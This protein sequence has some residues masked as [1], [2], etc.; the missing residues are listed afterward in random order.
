MARSRWVLAALVALVSWA[1]AA[2]GL[3]AT[4]TAVDCGSGANLQAA[5]TAAKPGTILLVSGACHG[6][7]TVGK[8]LV[9]KGASG[10][11]STPNEQAPRSRSPP[12]RC[13]SLG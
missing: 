13:A 7:I 10:R 11:F 2:P 1:A 8:N 4:Q 12:G 5:I 6:P 9:L 3:A